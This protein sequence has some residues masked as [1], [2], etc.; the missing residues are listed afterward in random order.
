MAD[1]I[2]FQQ[3]IND[4]AQIGDILYWTPVDAA[5][6]AAPT[7]IEIGPITEIGNNFVVVDGPFATPAPGTTPFFMF[8][9][10]NEAN[11]STLV[12]YFANVALSNDSTE[13]VELFSVG[14]EVFV[15]SK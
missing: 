11:I 3:E 4:S 7:P 5:N 2:N 9:K 13:E 15:S 1:R 6:N 12:G 10:N 8:R 14:S